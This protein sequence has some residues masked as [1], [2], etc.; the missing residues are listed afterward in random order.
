M[1]HVMTMFDTGATTDVGK[2]RE[3]NEDS[4]LA[5]PDAGVW[6]VADGMGGHSDGKLASDTLIDALQA[7][8]VPA[9]EES[10]LLKFKSK[11]TDANAQIQG[12]S[13]RNGEII[14]TTLAAF[15]AYGRRYTCL[16]A[17]DSRI[18]VVRNGEISQ[19]SR[20]HTEVQELINSG[21]ITPAE[22][23]FWPGR[24]AITRAIG[25]FDRVELEAMSG[26]IL[27]GDAFVICSDGLT[28]HVSDTEICDYVSASDSQS[29]CDAL[30][31]LTLE[32]GAVDNV[33]VIVVRYRPDPQPAQESQR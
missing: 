13:R 33:T 20:D 29:A 4:F 16:W 22:A 3:N 30:V 10:L 2:L 25:V 32:R 23:K 9:S 8:E 14:G 1:Q 21:A 24:N 15:L 27:P 6:A 11:V 28:Q 18:Y 31:A 19:L 26:D 12:V 7:I 17:G 5:R